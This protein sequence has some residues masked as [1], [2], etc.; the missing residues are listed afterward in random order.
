MKH[1]A[2]LNR[3]ASWYAARTL[4]ALGLLTILFLLVSPTPAAEKAGDKFNH[5]STGFPLTGAHLQTDCQTCHVRGIFKGTPQQC[6]ACH[7]QGSRLASTAK[8]AKHVQTTEACD[9][10]HSSTVTWT[11]ARFRHAGVVPGSCMTCHNGSTAMG[12]PANHVQ[13]TS[14]CDSCHRTTAWIPA[15]YNHAGV[16]PGSCATCHNGTTATGKP[17][18]HLVTAA[19]C[20][21]CHR[22]TAWIPATFSHAGVVPGT[23]ATCHNGSTATGKPAT[24]LVTTASCDACHRTTAWIPATFSHVGVAP[25]TCATCHNGTSATGKPATHMVTTKSCDACHTTN[26]PWTTVRY[27]HTSPNYKIHNAGVTCKGC[28]TT[29]NEVIAWKF[30]AYVPDCA[31]CHA[32]KYKAD[33]HK[34]T[35]VP[36]TILYTVAELKNCAGSCHLYT[37]STFS[38]IKTPRSSRHRSTD[39]GF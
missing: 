28:H 16:T 23:C 34:K 8:P 27:T 15:G 33:S 6:A 20:D 9:Q 17:P 26:P 19:A 3:R 22:T 1:S 31:A 29:N 35:E 18:R 38:S 30:G 39:G 13:T 7:T 11:G 10:C 14:S 36:T 2:E 5:L 25:G 12:K 24:H 4:A 32:D 37:D 21:A